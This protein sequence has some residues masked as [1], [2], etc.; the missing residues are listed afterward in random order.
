VTGVATA[1]RTGTSPATDRRAALVLAVLMPVGPALVAVL[2]GLL[3]GFTAGDSRQMAAAVAA[4]PGRESAVLWL[5]YLATL[6]LVPGAIAAAGLA[7]KGAPRLAAWAAALLVPGYLSMGALLT[8][9]AVLWAGQSA[10]LPTA[11]TAALYD[12]L[13][14]S[15]DIAVGVFVV[16]HVAGTVLLGLALLRARAIPAS[17]AWVLTVS[18]PLHFV[19]FVVFGIQTLDVVAW[20]LTTVGMAAAAAALVRRPR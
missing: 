14:P 3:P 18:Q 5:G 11:A 17:F 10:G 13:H 20:T 6:M 12:H 1:G 4:S 16:G 15:I 9:D 8:G 7:R 19:A 2:R